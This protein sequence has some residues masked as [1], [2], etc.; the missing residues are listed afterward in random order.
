[1]ACMIWSHKVDSTT[2]GAYLEFNDSIGRF[3]PCLE[4]NDGVGGSNASG[5]FNDGTG[6]YIFQ[7]IYLKVDIVIYTCKK[8]EKFSIPSF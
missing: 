3:D 5:A 4:F 8:K 7:K 2:T 6:S 1:M